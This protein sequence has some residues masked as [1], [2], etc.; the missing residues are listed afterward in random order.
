[1]ADGPRVAYGAI[2]RPWGHCLRVAAA[3]TRRL[4][5]VAYMPLKS[6]LAAWDF[7]TVPERIAKRAVSACKKHRFAVQNG[8]FQP[9]KRHV[10]QRIGSQRVMQGVPSASALS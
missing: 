7:N 6:R 10:P 4:T 9:S 3:Y 1:M 2:C 8:T 5:Q